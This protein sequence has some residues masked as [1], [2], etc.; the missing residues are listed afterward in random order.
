MHR[1]GHP[2]MM[3]QL[4]RV[5]FRIPDPALEGE[6]LI[7]LPTAWKLQ[8]TRMKVKCKVLHLSHSNGRRSSRLGAAAIENSP[9][10]KNLRVMVDEKL[11][12]LRSSLATITTAQLFGFLSSKI[13]YHR[14]II[15]ISNWPNP[16][17]DLPGVGSAGHGGSF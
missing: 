2:V 4:P 7:F 14:G 10:E 9:V 17:L 15:A 13:Y 3:Q 16:P 1:Q 12:S 8:S 11:N 5:W 6:H